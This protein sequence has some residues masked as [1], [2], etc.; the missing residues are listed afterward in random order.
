[1]SSP[2][3][4]L[5]EIFSS[6]QGEGI[7]V[8]CRQIFLRFAGCNLTCSYCDTPRDIPRHCRWEARPGSREFLLLPNPLTPQEVALKIRKLNPAIHHSI[9]LTGGEPLLHTSFL[10][11]LIPLLKGTRQG[12]YLETNGTLP[13]NLERILPLVDIIAMD[14]KLPGTANINPC[15]QEHR[16]FLK[17]ARGKHVFVKLVVDEDSKPEEIERALDLICSVGDIP[18]VIQPVTT[19]EGKTR[20]KPEIAITW[21]SR[22]LERLTDVRVIPQTH[23]FL[24]HL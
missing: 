6:I 9:S 21:Q 23:K 12:I 20:L 19:P 5:V 2:V 1:M 14:I 13:D 10:L 17:L 15:W 7:W 22:A 16:A 3:A 18:L 4:P 8:G 11:E 24:G